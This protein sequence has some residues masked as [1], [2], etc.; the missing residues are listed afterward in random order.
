MLGVLNNF[1]YKVRGWF[2]HDAYDGVVHSTIFVHE[3]KVTEQKKLCRSYSCLV[4][5][6]SIRNGGVG[7]LLA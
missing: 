3:R 6:R 5:M 1:R 4:L 2:V 7:R